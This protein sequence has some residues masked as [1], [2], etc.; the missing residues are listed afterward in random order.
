MQTFTGLRTIIMTVGIIA[1][2]FAGCKSSEKTTDD[3]E[4]G[5]RSTSAERISAEVKSRA[6][7]IA[8]RA[9]AEARILALPKVAGK[10]AVQIGAYLT[11]ENALKVADLAKERFSLMIY[12]YH[13]KT[14]NLYKVFIGDFLIKDEARNYRDEMVGKFPGEYN[15]AW[16]SE[17]PAR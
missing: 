14:D 12:T 13:D 3:Q 10:Y 11:P 7:S 1:L 15:D 6:D 5:T 4:S 16:V 2:I 17:H 9:K 8:A